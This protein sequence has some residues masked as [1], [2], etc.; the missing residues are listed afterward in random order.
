MLLD[1]NLAGYK[2]TMNGSCAKNAFLGPIVPALGYQY[3]VLTPSCAAIE[4]LHLMICEL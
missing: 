1:N 4:S 2:Q 3:R